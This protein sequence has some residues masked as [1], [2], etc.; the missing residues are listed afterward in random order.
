[1]KFMPQ[2]IFEVCALNIA[3]YKVMDPSSYSQS[4]MD[5]YKIYKDD[6]KGD[7]IWIQ[8][9]DEIADQIISL[10]KKCGANDVVFMLQV[11][12]D[13]R[14]KFDEN[15][16]LLSGAKSVFH[17]TFFTKS[18]PSASARKEVAMRNIQSLFMW[19]IGRGFVP[20]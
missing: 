14:Q 13:V 18:H 5:V 3:K 8:Q 10:C 7:S 20:R 19:M 12:Q 2:D 6:F 4:K 1:M 9:C 11:A 16:E 17:G 15:M